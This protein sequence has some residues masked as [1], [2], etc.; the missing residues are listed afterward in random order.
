[1]K[2]ASAKAYT[3]GGGAALICF[4]RDTE[5]DLK[6]PLVITAIKDS[7]VGL[8]PLSRWYGIEQALELGLITEVGAGT[9]FNDAYMLGSQKYYW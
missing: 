8:K 1:M 6:T 5:E 4:S 3:Y 7:F 2:D 9:G